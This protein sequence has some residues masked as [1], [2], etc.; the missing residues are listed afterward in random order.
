MTT[1]R[2]FASRTQKSASTYIGN[3]GSL[4]YNEVDGELRLSDGVT[5]GG[6]AI[7][8]RAD[9]IV[10]Q[11]LTPALDN[12]N[13]YGLGDETHR[14]YDLHIGDGGIHYNGF[15]DP[16]Y[17]PY[18]PGA[19]VDDI[20]PALDNDIDLGAPDKRFANIYLGY[21][22][23]YLADQTTD[24]NIN[25]T[26]DNGTLY[27]NG[28]ANLAIGNLVIRD[29]TLQSLTTNLDINI[30]ETNDTG[31][32]YVR[33]KAQFDNVSF[34]STEAMVSMNASGGAD[35][36]TVFPDTVLQTVSRPNKNS[37]V[38]Q[39]SYGSTGNVGGD[40]AYA[41]WASYAARGNTAAPAALKAN[42]I[43]ARVSANGYGTS[44][45]GSGGARME[46]VALE[47]FTDTAKGTRINFWTTPSGQIASQNVASINS[48]GVIAAGIEFSGDSTVQTTAGIPLSAK[49]VSS[50]TYVAT[51]GVDGKL[52]ASQIPASL[53]GAIVFKGGWDANANTPSLANGSGSDGWEYAITI[54]GTRSLGTQTGSVTYEPGGYVIYGNGIWNYTPPFNN[55]TY[56]TA[57][58][59]THIKVNGNQGTQETGVI[60]VTSDATPNA[61]TSTIVSRDASGNFAANVITAN[62]TG[63]VTGS[64]SGNAGSVT[65]GV[66]TTG[67]QTIDGT[68]TFTSTI[69]GTITSATLAASVVGGIG[70]AT[71]AGSSGTSVS[72]STGAV[73]VWFNTSTLVAQAVSATTAT[74]AGYA[75]SFNTSTLVAQ[76]VSATTATNAGY[77]YSFNTG[78]LVTNAVNATTATNAA[79]AY[80]FNTGT[81]VTTAVSA[82]TA[83][84]AAYAYSFNTG[85]LVTTAVNATTATNAAYAYSFNTGTLVT[86]A[87]TAGKVAN[88]LTAGFGLALES[89][90]TYDGGAA[91]TINALHGVTGPVT[92]SG[93]AYALDLGAANGLIILNNVSQ[94]NYTITISNPVAGKVVRV[95]C[96]N[97]K[98]GAGATTVTVSG[99]TAANSSNGGNTFQGNANGAV[100]I[101]EFLCTTTATSGV[102]MNTGGAK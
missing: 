49:A 70:V 63:A 88:A 91:H 86:T 84:N 80:S 92:V 98:T 60:T 13:A 19:Q 61:T 81:L 85:T 41:V 76:A 93:N 96:L 65:N 35:P 68:K 53:S 9:L 1:Q 75:Y 6:V 97:M 39:R 5:P 32:F 34:G 62:L 44:T 11:R 15:A 55:I 66:Y 12:N 21:D 48:V 24:A 33:R 26:V 2:I 47:N 95:M 64:V 51:L 38:V 71:L 50:A 37:R 29:T 23:L 4:F 8:V 17:V 7:S 42:D 52:D 30:G 90:T 99:L 58:A 46:F 100:A 89:G 16:Q 69:Q 56:V 40:N 31:F 79:Y 54:Q 101:V 36:A 83:T 72:A 20:I 94:A 22:G 59:G 27:V 43:L 14:W 82:T 25:I 77:A 3:P 78:T 74:N 10:A 87:V 57:T 102:Y 73:T 45:W 67:G 28:A 18:R